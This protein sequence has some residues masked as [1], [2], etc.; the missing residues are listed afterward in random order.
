M[1]YLDETE[2]VVEDN[3]LNIDHDKLRI[4]II[5]L[6]N[7]IDKNPNFAAIEEVRSRLN[8]YVDIYLNG[9]DNTP[10]YNRQNHSILPRVKISYE[11]FLSV[12][13]TSKYYP[14]VL[15]LYEKIR[16]NKFKLR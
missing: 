15:K 13:Y 14:L 8:W 9:L 3:G 1:S 12:N 6:E 2:C 16:K 4:Y 11:R 10:L 7:F 5:E